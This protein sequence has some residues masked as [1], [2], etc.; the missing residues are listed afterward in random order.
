MTLEIYVL[1]ICKKEECKLWEVTDCTII[2]LKVNYFSYVR[3]VHVHIF[4][5]KLFLHQLFTAVLALKSNLKFLSVLSSH[6]QNFNTTTEAFE[7]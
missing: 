4:F 2:F 5:L 7:I 3:N 6:Y 1:N